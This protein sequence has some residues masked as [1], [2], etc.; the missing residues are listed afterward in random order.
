MLPDVAHLVTVGQDEITIEL[1]G[2]NTPLSLRRSVRIPLAAIRSIKTEQGTASLS[3][4]T[5]VA[6]PLSGV[7]FG[8]VIHEGRRL[9]LAYRPGSPP[10][11][12]EL[13]REHYPGLDYDAVVLGVD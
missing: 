12:L 3:L 4:L 7:R 10:V 1:S 6:G 2:P 9:L 8:S 11:T 13:D 5:R